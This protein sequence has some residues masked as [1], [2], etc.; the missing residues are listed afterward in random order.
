[1]HTIALLLTIIFG[2]LGVIHLYW[3]AGG[4]FG[5]DGVL[6][7]VNDAPLFTPGPLVTIAVACLLGVFS[8]IAIILG[9]GDD[10]IGAY[11]NHAIISAYVI[12]TILLLRA[13]GDFRYVGFFKRVKGSKFAVYDS[14]LFSPL[15]FLTGCGYF[16]LAAYRA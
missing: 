3:A 5:L 2:T 16:F 11:L 6:P 13:I 4:A 10:S 8:I 15:C 9:F 12:G 14:W 7:A 1:M